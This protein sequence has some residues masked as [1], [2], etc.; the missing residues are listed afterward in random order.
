MVV[1]D[2]IEVILLSR[3]LMDILRLKSEVTKV[4]GLERVSGG[5]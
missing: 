1:P 2:T 4:L 5:S 3:V